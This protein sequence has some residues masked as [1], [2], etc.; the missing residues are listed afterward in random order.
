MDSNKGPIYLM[1]GVGLLGIVIIALGLVSASGD[2]YTTIIT[3]DAT[4]EASS[5]DTLTLAST[6]SAGEVGLTISGDAGTDTITL[7]LPVSSCA[8]TGSAVP[9]YYDPATG[10][11]TC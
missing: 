4:L 2:A 7:T 8:A 10:G 6:G 11:L 3:P 5:G 1:I 9:L